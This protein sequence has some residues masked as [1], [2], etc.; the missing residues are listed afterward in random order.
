MCVCV[1]VFSGFPIS[2]GG[3]LARG[4]VSFLFC[5]YHFDIKLPTFTFLFH[6]S[7]SLCN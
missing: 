5:W 7:L 2:R 1:F 4:V 3:I 6:S